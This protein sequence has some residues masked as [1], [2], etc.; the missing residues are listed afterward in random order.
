VYFELEKL[1]GI[2]RED[3]PLKPD[4]FVTTVDKLFGVGAVTV[5]RAIR[6]E[7]ETSSGIK[8]LCKKDLLTALRMAYHEQLEKQS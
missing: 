7:L 5:S 3:I 2:S 1:F 4:L 6:R 8:D